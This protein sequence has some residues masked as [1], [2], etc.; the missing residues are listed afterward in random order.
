[1]I[2]TEYK[3]FR[4]TFSEDSESWWCH[5]LEIENDNSLSLRALKARIDKMLTEGRR[6]KDFKA[7][8]FDGGAGRFAHR[9]SVQEVTV[10]MLC[11]PE[12]DY[13]YREKI[14]KR[15]WVTNSKGDRVKIGL[16]RLSPLSAKDAMLEWCNLCVL[17]DEAVQK[18]DDAKNTIP[19]FGTAEA[20]IRAAKEAQVQ[21]AEAE[22]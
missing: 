16:D 1:M 21:K 7:L 11:A 6:L 14:V 10:S 8:M 18:A 3:G 15:A 9:P 19:T 22:A 5:D 20:V 13:S 2:E 4:L 17:A 12:R